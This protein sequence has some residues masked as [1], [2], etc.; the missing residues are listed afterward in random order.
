MATTLDLKS[1]FDNDL[2]GQKAKLV[3]TGTEDKLTESIEYIRT[4][5]PQYEKLEVGMIFTGHDLSDAIKADL[6]QLTRVGFYPSTEAEKELDCAIKH[7]LTGSYKA[8]FADLRRALELILASVYLTSPEVSKEKAIRWMDSEENTP[9][10]SKMVDQLSRDERFKGID[11]TCQWREN[12]KNLYWKLSD[13]SHNKGML[14][15]YA[16]LNKRHSQLGMTF[17]L[18]INMD[19]VRTLC[20]FYLEVVGEIVAMLAIYNPIILVGLPLDTKFGFNPPFSGFFYDVQADRA[21]SL[22]P[23]KYKLFFDSM[24]RNSPEIKGITQWMNDQPDMTEDQLKEQLREQDIL[25]SKKLIQPP[26][27]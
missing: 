6:Q 11:Q 7:T 22:L 10:F 5:Y 24:R 23:E 15:G 3:S 21:L 27:R 14:K 19:T 1:F 18:G 9:M 8:A 12:I 25:F 17:D 2:L 4:L 13:F 16:E 26:T 20:D